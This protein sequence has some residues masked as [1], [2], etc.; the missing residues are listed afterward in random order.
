MGKCFPQKMAL[1]D[2]KIQASSENLR[3]S[4]KK[5]GMAQGSL[6]YVGKPNTEHRP[7]IKIIDYDREH[8]EEHSVKNT[9]DFFSMPIP[10]STSDCKVNWVNLDGVQDQRIIEKFGV[11]YQLDSLVLEDIMNTEQRPKVEFFDKYLF[12]SMK[13]LSYDPAYNA[14][15]EE[16]VSCVLGKNYVLSF[17]E[18]PGDVFDP[19]RERIR[20]KKGGIHQKGADY[21][22]CALVDI[23]IDNYFV[24]L[25][26]IAQS[27]YE[28]E[29][30]LF[31]KTKD[32]R[33]E[34]THK[35]IQEHKKI[36]MTIQR[37]IYPMKEAINRL[38]RNDAGVMDERNIKYLNDVHDHATQVAE[39]VDFLRET[40]VGL[41]D[42]YLSSLSN[43][44]NQ[45]MQVLTIIS[46]IFIPLTFIVGVYGMNFKHMPEIYWKYGYGSIWVLMALITGS[47][48]Y[49]FRKK[50]WI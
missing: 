28:I 43:K 35:I 16:Q 33:E 40:N 13:M 21:L 47:L 4:A 49:Y 8:L 50:K 18:K 14:L 29:E 5:V 9:D 3:H 30:K 26:T 12:V 41:Q 34:N 7:S 11:K 19:L 48:L 31:D 25:D 37:C 22:L 39:N 6:V 10:T 36:I 38:K 27:L 1:R 17:Q 20:K 2:K 45:I 23:V 24:I 15:D 32:H 46:T 44:T 42:I